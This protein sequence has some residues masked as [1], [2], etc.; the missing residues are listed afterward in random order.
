MGPTVLGELHDF[1]LNNQV[2]NGRNRTKK[3]PKKKVRGTKILP[4]FLF[5]WLFD[6]LEEKIWCGGSEEGF[7]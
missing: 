6:W 5:G 7:I 2:L 1:V 4:T 3:S